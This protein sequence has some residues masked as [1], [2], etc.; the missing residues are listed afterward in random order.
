MGAAAAAAVG[1]FAG[2]GPTPGGA[3]SHREAPL[4]S[5]D[6][7]SGQHRSLRVRQSEQA[8]PPVTI[9]SNWIPFEEP[10]RRAEFLRV[11]HG[12]D[13][14]CGSTTMPTPRPDIVYRWTFRNHWR[15]QD[16]FL[17]NTVRSRRLTTRT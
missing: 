13:T 3:S 8:G 16:T 17:Y 14:T 5:A 10:R 6:P 7:A 9:V 2:L 12:I 15:N 11:R 1:V 4:I